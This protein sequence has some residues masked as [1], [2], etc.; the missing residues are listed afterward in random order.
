MRFSTGYKSWIAYDCYEIDQQI[1]WKFDQENFPS[2]LNVLYNLKPLKLY[3]ET[4][5]K[6]PYMYSYK[7][8]ETWWSPDQHPAVSD[9]GNVASLRMRWDAFNLSPVAKP[10]W[11]K[12]TSCLDYTGHTRVLGFIGAKFT[13]YSRFGDIRPIFE[14]HK[15]KTKSIQLWSPSRPQA[16]K[17][18]NKGRAFGQF[19][20]NA[21][22][23]KQL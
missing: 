10:A 22:V 21:V 19:N 3:D 12:D 7:W 5:K 23:L 1:L 8:W 16:H 14:E 6:P 20:A 18:A 2:T 11:V 4:P 9:L 17:L 13:D 15:S